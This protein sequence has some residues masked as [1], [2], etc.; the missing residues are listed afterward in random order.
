MPGPQGEPGPQ[1]PQGIQGV[2]GPQG[3]PGPQGPQGP[4]GAT[5]SAYRHNIQITVSDGSAL[6]ITYYNSN[7]QPFTTFEDFEREITGKGFL[8]ISGFKDN[9]DNECSIY[10]S[11]YYDGFYKGC[12]IKGLLIGGKFSSQTGDPLEIT[13]IGA[14]SNVI[15]GPNADSTILYI[16]DVVSQL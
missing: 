7:E 6:Y 1:G 9:Y 2:P 8:S 15:T 5:T 12:V 13:N 3:E 11:M 4:T 10:T 14:D 16:N